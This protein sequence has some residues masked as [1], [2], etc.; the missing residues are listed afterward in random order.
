MY[1]DLTEFANYPTTDGLD[2]VLTF[3]IKEHNTMK[4]ET[5]PYTGADLIAEL[6]DSSGTICTGNAG[7]ITICYPNDYSAIIVANASPNVE[8]ELYRTVVSAK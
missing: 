8:I 7:Q 1:S 3:L 2:E 5:S 6:V 4:G